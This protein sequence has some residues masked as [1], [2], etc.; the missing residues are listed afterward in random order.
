MAAVPPPPPSEQQLAFLHTFGHLHL[1]G[2]LADRAGEITAAFEALMRGHGGGTHT[3]ADQRLS[4]APFLNHSPA[5]CALLDD[6]RIDG[7]ARAL[8]GDDYQYWNSDGNYYVGDTEWHSDYNWAHADP[9][10][11][12]WRDRWVFYKLALYL[13]PLTAATGALRV[14]PGSHLAGDAFA[15]GV[16]RQLQGNAQ[17]W[18]GLESIGEAPPGKWGGLPGAAVPAVALET[19]PG[20]VVVFPGASL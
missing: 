8:C 13:D 6:P 2:L 17:P 18:R 19:T 3:P 14:I 10:A 1:P 5:L 9:A 20:D 11:P 4:V 15:D 7:L 12:P 16:D